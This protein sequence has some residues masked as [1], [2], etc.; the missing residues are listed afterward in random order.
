VWRRFS[1]SVGRGSR[2]V[3][4]LTIY[5]ITVHSPTRLPNPSF[6][7]CFATVTRLE[8][9]LAR[10]GVGTLRLSSSRRHSTSVWQVSCFASSLSLLLRSRRMWSLASPSPLLSLECRVLCMDVV[11]SGATNC[12]C[13][14]VQVALLRLCMRLSA[15]LPTSCWTCALSS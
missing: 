2:R 7:S 1:K 13:F 9:T 12:R 10:S 14:H 4:V 5:S 3:T 8:S 11:V 6:W 15:I